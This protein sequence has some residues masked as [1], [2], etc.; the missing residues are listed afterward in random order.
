MSNDKFLVKD[1]YARRLKR[2]LPSLISVS[3][4]IILIFY[5]SVYPIIYETYLRGLFWNSIYLVNVYLNNYLNYFTQDAFY[6]PFLHLWSISVEEQFYILYPL[7]F[8]CI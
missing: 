2:L 1:F 3:V 7:Y 4:L 8:F 6:N 5:N